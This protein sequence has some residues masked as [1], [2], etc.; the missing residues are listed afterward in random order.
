MHVAGALATLAILEFLLI[1]S[2]IGQ[3]YFQTI[4][5]SK[6]YGIAAFGVFIVISMVAN[7]WA[8]SGLSREKQYLGLGLYITALSLFFLP[9]FYVANTY[10]P[11]IMG[12]AFLVTLALVAGITFTAFTSKVN[13]SFLGKYLYVGMFVLIGVA[14]SGWIFGFSLGLWFSGAAILVFGGFVLYDTSKIIHEYSTE[15]HVAASLALFASIAFLF[16]NVL[17][18]FMGMAGED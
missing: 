16:I 8:H 5:A 7:S 18:F 10:Y 1:Q 4:Q 15:Q 6:W 11:G 9:T 2:G 12:H 13:F 17:Q 3:S 14:I